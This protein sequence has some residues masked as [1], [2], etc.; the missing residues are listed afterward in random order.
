MQPD[1]EG[2]ALQIL[3]PAGFGDRSR[4]VG[5]DDPRL[6]LLLFMC[7]GLCFPK[8]CFFLSVYVA[9]VP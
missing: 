7:L 1:G 5:E 9:P 4:S 6:L 2:R 8:G 3:F